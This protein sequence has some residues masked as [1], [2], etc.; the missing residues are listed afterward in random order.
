MEKMRNFMQ[1]WPGKL[2]LVGTLIP[3]AFLGV[4]GTF[5]GAS[6]QP[7]QLI[8]VGKQVIGVDVFQS[9][10]NN[11]RAE[12][13]KQVDA[14]LIN[15]SALANEVLRNLISRALLE[16][17]AVSLGM[18]VSDET[19]TRLLQSEP[20]FL[21]ANGQFS[22]DLFAQFLQHSGMNKD[23]LFQNFRTQLSL[24]QLNASILGTAIYPDAQ[25][26][27]LLDL[28]LEAREV[29]VKR[30]DWQ[31]YASQ[32]QV[33]D[34]E[35]RAY[36][37][38]NKDKLIKSATVDLAYLELDPDLIKVEAPTED[39]I[40]AQYENYLKDRG[41]SDDRELAQILLTG[42]DAEK[43]ANELYDKLNKGESFE[44]LAKQYSDDPS[45][46]SGGAIGTYNPEVFGADAGLVNQALAG[47]S[48]GKYSKPVKTSFGYQIFKV[49]KVNDNAPKIESIRPELVALATTYKRQAAFADLSAKINGMT[50]DGVG[51]AD[52]AKNTGLELKRIEHYTQT[53]NTSAL[54]QPAVI[55]AA[56]DEFTIQDQGV[57]PNITL[58][59]K[60]VWVQPS[61]Y[62][63]ARPLTLEEAQDDIRQILVRQQAI[64]LAVKEAQS[65]SEAAAGQG[66]TSL[67]ASAT[68][69]GVSTRANP[70]LTVQERAS[71]FLHQSEQGFDV[72]FVQT[73]QGAS[74]MVGGPVDKA[75]QAQLAPADRLR[76][77]QVLRDNVGADQLEDYLQ[78]LRDSQEVVI[79]E[80]AL[81]AQT[82]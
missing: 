38:K 20:A 42:T 46:K 67:M 60:A 5:G 47:L 35:I 43:R 34:Q 12:L 56:F 40:R 1:S 59:N 15:E 57:S 62:Q 32:V 72:W 24:R 9:E 70:N 66:S 76:A 19:I 28:Q 36:F 49:T 4:Q 30:Y 39:E 6:I 25:I 78:Y 11:Y 65:V 27:R 54:A 61:N 81:Q 26:S 14:S 53:G 31:N 7:N 75:T 13:L 80:D 50:T 23:T 22:N 55:A 41:I 8:K 21:D 45:G 63:A 52:I 17:Q 37:D 71:L 48:V 64:A 68:K 69:M 77:V 79:N 29:W 82:H 18:T 51:V 58:G 16:H 33:S 74:V 2:I 44:M 3:M 73:D 10:V